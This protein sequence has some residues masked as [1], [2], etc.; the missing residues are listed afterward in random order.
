M[1][2]CQRFIRPELLEKY[3]IL[4]AQVGA[5]MDCYIPGGAWLRL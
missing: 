3:T 4:Q 2:F 1:F 5:V